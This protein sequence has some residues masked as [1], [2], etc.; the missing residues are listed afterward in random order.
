MCESE[1]SQ[2]LVLECLGAGACDCLSKP[3]KQQDL[4]GLWQH[5]WRRRSLDAPF[6]LKNMGQFLG[7]ELKS[8]KAVLSLQPVE[9]PILGMLHTSPAAGKGSCGSPAGKLLHMCDRERLAPD[10]ASD[11]SSRECLGDGSAGRD[12]SGSGGDRPV[13]AAESE[14]EVTPCSTRCASSN[15][16]PMPRASS[17]PAGKSCARPSPCGWLEGSHAEGSSLQT[18]PPG[19]SELPNRPG[20]EASLSGGPWL[21]D[22]SPGQVVFDMPSLSAYLYMQNLF[23]QAMHTGDPAYCSMA[24]AWA[25]QF[26]AMQMVPGA[27]VGAPAEMRPLELGAERMV[28]AKRPR[29]E[30]APAETIAQSKRAAAIAKFREKRKN[31]NFERKVR[32]GALPRRGGYPP[33][34]LP[35]AAG[36]VREPQEARGRAAPCAGAVCQA[37]RG[38]LLVVSPAPRAGPRVLIGCAAPQPRTDLHSHPLRF[39]RI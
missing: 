8:G 4:S 30:D 36:S 22:G 11:V 17:L 6:P 34:T 13:S 29:P 27:A 10:Q 26:G 19:P 35:R 14:D 7:H 33:L 24:A 18:A 20:T 25:Q 1:D 28:P 38:G 21:A 39:F 32:N 23:S 16:E 2:D 5:V 3:V 12:P 37:V 31:R 15:E 9:M